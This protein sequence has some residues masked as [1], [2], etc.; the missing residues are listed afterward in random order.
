MIDI[1]QYKQTELEKMKRGEQPIPQ[2]FHLVETV[3]GPRLIASLNAPAADETEEPEET[4]D[5]ATPLVS[6]SCNSWSLSGSARP[7]MTELFESYWFKGEISCLFAD[8]N[9]GKS[10][11]A[12]QIAHDLASRGLRVNYFDF[13]M[14]DAQFSR[15]YSTEEGKRFRWPETLFRT[16]MHIENVDPLS[17]KSDDVISHIERNC[18]LNDTPYIIIDNITTLTPKGQDGEMALRMMGKLRALKFKHGWSILV[19]AH[20]PKRDKSQPLTDND[21]AGSKNLFNVFDS[22]FGMSKAASSGTQRYTKQLK[23]RSASISYG[24]DNVQVWELNPSPED[25]F[26]HFER[27]RCCPEDELLSGGIPRNEGIP[28]AKQ[29]RAQGKGYKKIAEEL[30]V[31]IGTAHNWA[32]M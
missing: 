6:K 20:T 28:M 25:G 24:A 9:T 32:N 21:L 12:M 26:L 8:S 31:S 29:M 16:E 30:G 4:A 14:S 5:S 1:S 18:L 15:R 2:G 27:V 10:I 13:E 11:M 22:V 19:I 3:N 23:V 7:P 17:F